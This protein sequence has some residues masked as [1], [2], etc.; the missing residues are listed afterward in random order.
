MDV[1]IS[2]DAGVP[3]LTLTGAFDAAG[4]Q[5][6]DEA[7]PT[8]DSAA[9][10][11]VVGLAGVGYISSIGLRS[12]VAVEKT[13]RAHGGGLVVT[14]A[15]RVVRQVLE[16]TRL[17]SWLRMAGDLHEAVAYARTAATPIAEHR[18]GG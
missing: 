7:V 2:F 10:A 9:R 11:W 4:A 12:L 3:V 5:R 18:I 14:G 15:T 16:L 13:L 8:V 1:R 6:F 17:D